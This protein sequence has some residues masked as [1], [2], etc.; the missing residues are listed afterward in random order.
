MF[1]LLL[2]MS[3]CFLS[4]PFCKNLLF[5]SY[6]NCKCLFSFFFSVNNFCFFLLGILSF[7]SFFSGLI[8]CLSPSSFTLVFIFYYYKFK[9]FFFWWKMCFKKKVLTFSV[10]DFSV[11]PCRIFF[12]F[13]FYCFYFCVTPIPSFFYVLFSDFSFQVFRL[14][15]MAHAESNN[16]NR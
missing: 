1:S 10:F 14:A 6:S 8:F 16:S 9:T 11:I 5:P 3:S 4:F 2:I 7:F 12:S 15:D 13:S